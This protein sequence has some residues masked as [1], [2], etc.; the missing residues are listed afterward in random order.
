MKSK[1]EEILNDVSGKFE[2]NEVAGVNAVA[3][4][5]TDYAAQDFNEIENPENIANIV[6]ENLGTDFEKEDIEKIGK[7]VEAEMNNEIEPVGWDEE[8]NKVDMDKINEIY[9]ENKEV[10]DKAENPFVENVENENKEKTENTETEEDKQN[11][12]ENIAEDAFNGMTDNLKNSENILDNAVGEMY[13]RW[14]EEYL[15]QKEA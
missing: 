11:L 6:N 4:Y 9:E 5:Y 7:I 3:E 2:N 12:I 10:L 14:R 15:E 1:I 8:N 13:D